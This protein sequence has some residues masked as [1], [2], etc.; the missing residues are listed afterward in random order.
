MGWGMLS[1]EETRLLAGLQKQKVGNKD[2]NLNTYFDDEIAKLEAKAGQPAAKADAA[3]RPTPKADEPQDDAAAHLRS[4]IP[5]R[6]K[7]P[8]KDASAVGV[9]AG[10]EHAGTAPT[11]PSV[12]KKSKSRRGEEPA[13]PATSEPAYP[14]YVVRQQSEGVSLE[15][16]EYKNAGYAIVPIEPGTKRPKNS[17]WVNGIPVEKFREYF[18]GKNPSGIGISL[19]G[20][21]RGL[22]DMDLDWEEAR[23]LADEFD[24][25]FGS[26]P[27]FGRKDAPRSHRLAICKEAM[28]FGDCST[29]AFTFPGTVAQKLGL[30]DSEEHAT[31]VLELRGNGGQ[32][33]F[34]PS[35][36]PSGQQVE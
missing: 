31:C 4:H 1:P 19:G 2:P 9:T 11:E 34:P 28:E 16:I 35:V 3:V 15:A 24:F 6:K 17:D 25:L 27:A 10:A 36:H 13:Q 18:G 22:I 33:I 23:K 14:P 21:S 20:R 12:K 8:A 32:T 26:M 29:L 30:S 7:A 5:P